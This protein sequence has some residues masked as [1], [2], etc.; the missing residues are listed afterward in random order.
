MTAFADQLFEDAAAG[1]NNDFFG[2]SVLYSRG[3]ATVTLTAIPEAQSDTLLDASGLQTVGNG[4]DY[5]F[6][7]GD[8]VLT[9]EVAEPCRGDTITETIGGTS[10][11]FEVLPLRAVTSLALGGNP[12]AELLPGGFRWLVHT[13][14]IA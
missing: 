10:C 6:A 7:V 5:T 2:V 14:R 9:S 12:V 1:I 13:K 4:R 11:V 8:L 3:A